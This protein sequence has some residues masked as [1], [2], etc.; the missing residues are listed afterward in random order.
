M[1]A[2]LDSLKKQIQR[3]D[4]R[5][6]EKNDA[7]R[8]NLLLR[9]RLAGDITVRGAIRMC[10]A[11]DKGW[12]TMGWVCHQLGFNPEE[13]AEEIKT[14]VREMDEN[15]Y[16]ITKEQGRHIPEGIPWGLTKFGGEEDV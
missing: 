8:E 12:Y 9:I 2:F 11:E 16:R 15:Y 13:S 1:R 4:F 5:K 10:W 6:K 14:I 7:D 3:E